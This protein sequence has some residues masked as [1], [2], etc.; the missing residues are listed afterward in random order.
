MKIVVVCNSAEY[1]GNYNEIYY[2]SKEVAFAKD[3]RIIKLNDKER[4]T[5]QEKDFVFIESWY[6]GL[7]VEE[8]EVI[9]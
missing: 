9:E 6:G 1:E 8:V 3:E 7:F 4:T 2:I 5:L